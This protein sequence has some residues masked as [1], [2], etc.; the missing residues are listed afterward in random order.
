MDYVSIFEE[1]G[2]EKQKAPWQRIV[3]DCKGT[4]GRLREAGRHVCGSKW[5]ETGIREAGTISNQGTKGWRPLSTPWL[6]SG[7]ILINLKAETDSTPKVTKDSPIS[8][9]QPRLRS[10]EFETRFLAKLPWK[11]SLLLYLP[12][13]SFLT[14][15]LEIKTAISLDY[16]YVWSLHMHMSTPR[17]DHRPL[18]PLGFQLSAFIQSLETDFKNRE[19]RRKEQ[20]TWN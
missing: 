18:F 9:K 3:V 13:L 1:R 14:Q 17:G 5:T 8:Q 2:I 4:K 15:K 7:G 11:V 10:W 16:G 6:H 20:S 19:E 12:D